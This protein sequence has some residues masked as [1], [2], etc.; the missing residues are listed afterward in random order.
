LQVDKHIL[1]Y[2]APTRGELIESNDR[3]L[4]LY[5]RHTLP[6]FLMNY[7][8]DVW[9]KEIEFLK[10]EFK[11]EASPGSPYSKLATRNDLLLTSLGSRFNAIVLDRI[12]RFLALPLDYLDSVDKRS[13]LDLDLF[14][15]VRVFVKNEPHKV[16][17]LL[18]GRVRLIMSVSLVDKMIEKLLS[19]HLCK[20]EISNWREIPSKPGI[21]FTETDNLSVYED[22]QN[23]GLPM[24]YADISGWDMN[25]K[26][27]MIKDAADFAILLCDNPSP[28]WV[29][30]LKFKSILETKSIYQFSDG[31]MVTPL[32]DGIVNSGKLKTSR[33]NSFIRVRLAD[34]VGSRK[35]IAA[36]DDTVENR[37]DDAFNK[38]RRLG[39]VLKDYQNVTDSFEFCSH[40]YS[41]NVTYPLNHEK[42]V[43]NLLSDD[44]SD[45]FLWLEKNSAFRAELS[46][47]HPMYHTIMRQLDSI[48]YNEVVGL[49]IIDI[50]DPLFINNNEC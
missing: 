23:S 40:W 3:L 32:F 22:V 6:L 18:Q 17:K 42:M 50:K 16:E 43:M 1:E 9:N 49:Q 10:Y 13:L 39:V 37:I 27:W 5:K 35:T 36:G 28:I 46:D 45:P 12:E 2:K 44:S 47:H 14:D 31:E 20:L 29:H 25:V 30:L 41:A 48:G 38:Y 4:K 24:S 7:D 33:D 34:L 11:K 26:P 19:R 21:G 8:R 15:P